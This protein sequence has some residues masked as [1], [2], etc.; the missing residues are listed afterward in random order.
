MNEVSSLAFG[1]AFDG[2]AKRGIPDERLVEGLPITV[3]VLRSFRK[4]IDWEL[5]VDL[6]ERLE[7]LVGGRVGLFDLGHDQFHGSSTFGFM[8]QVA[9][10]FRRPRDL[11]WMGTTW[12]GRTI[13]SIVEGEFED[14][15]DKRIREV[16]RIPADRRDCPQLFHIMHGVLTA[17]PNLLR[18]PD[19]RVEMDLQPR[20]ATYV[21]TPPQREKFP[22]RGIAKLT[23]RFAAWDLID[24]MSKQQGELKESLQEMGT[25]REE[26]AEQLRLVQSIGHELCGQVGVEDLTRALAGAFEKHLPDRKIALWLQPLGGGDETLLHRDTGMT[27]PPTRVH[28]LQTG[29][30]VVGRLEIWGEV[31]GSSVGCGDLLESLI[32]WIALALDGARSYAA[33]RTAA[34]GPLS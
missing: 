20:E 11:Y 22:R 26:M 19:S 33:L 4:R 12:F 14:L 10:V 23:S 29:R 1:M 13:F 34:I 16:I 21:I 27:G 25:E 15:P 8:R 28:P 7:E 3:E 9:R 31:S 17:A 18:Y 2:L 5:F 30:G 24:A 32:P 6:I